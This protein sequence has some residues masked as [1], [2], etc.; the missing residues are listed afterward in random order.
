MKGK[1]IIIALSVVLLFSDIPYFTSNGYAENEINLLPWKK[2]NK[3]LPK[4]SKFIVMDIETGKKFWV[5][6]RAGSRHADVQPI[7]HHDTKIMKQIY[8]GK[9]SWRR[10]A[11]IV[12]SN[13]KKIAGSMHGMPHGGGALENNFPGHFCIH[14]F[15]ST[16]HRTNNMD[17]SHKLMILKAA[18]QLPSHLAKPDP[19]EVVNA[20]F[21]GLKEQDQAIVSMISLQPM[22]WK[23]FLSKIEAVRVTQM[24]VLPIEDLNAEIHM[25]I[26]INVNWFIE[27]VGLKR[28]HGNIELI[29]FSQSDPWKVD[30]LSFLENNNLPFKL[31]EKSLRF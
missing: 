12:I 30:S 26:P 25:S 24:A 8:N 2:V 28:F 17:L 14:F 10:R 4:Y 3:V 11:I 9:W 7:T 27:G 29:R 18:G 16:T 6:R 31:A 19:Y 22:Q 5:Q 20:Y 1:I 23:E 13:N 21:A 15:G